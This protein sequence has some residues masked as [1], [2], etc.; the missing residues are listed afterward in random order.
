MR[1]LRANSTAG[2][3]ECLDMGPAAA[4]AP[5]IHTLACGVGVFAGWANVALRHFHEPG[6]AALGAVILC[7]DNLQKLV[8]AGVGYRIEGAVGRLGKAK[9][10]RASPAGRPRLALRRC[11]R[12]LSQV[13]VGG[14]WRIRRWTDAELTG[15]DTGLRLEQLGFRCAVDRQCLAKAD[16]AVLRRTA[17]FRLGRESE[18]FFWR[19]ATAH[20]RWQS[21]AG[22]AALAIGECVIGPWRP[23]LFAR[24]AGRVC[25]AVGVALHSTRPTPVQG[26]P[27][28]SPQVLTTRDSARRR[29]PGERPKS[30][31]RLS[32]CSTVAAWGHR[33]LQRIAPGELRKAGK[34]AVR[35]IQFAAVLHRQGGQMGIGHEVRG[36][37]PNQQQLAEK[38]P[39]PFR[40][41]HDADTRLS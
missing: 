5:V 11:G 24:L 21:L 2:L 41:V 3:A 32:G 6:T 10:P 30:Q 39:V 8:S 28:G 38:R 26:V 4:R 37:C 7:R 23:S 9:T 36:R 33:F 17:A 35:R 27:S 15:A 34:I 31:G 13:G 16:P 12:V 1:F 29:L 40:R 14:G 18:R 20:G 25:G 19:W 22:H